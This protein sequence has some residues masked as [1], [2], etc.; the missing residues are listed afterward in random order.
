M[1]SFGRLESRPNE[2]KSM[3]SI[4]PNS[5]DVITICATWAAKSLIR[6]RS[7]AVSSARPSGRLRLSPQIGK[8]GL[9]LVALC[10]CRLKLG[11][12]QRSVRA[13]LLFGV[14]RFRLECRELREE[15]LDLGIALAQRS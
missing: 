2:C 7:C 10:F 11:L 4:G 6:L 9:S 13:Q 1:P 8:F 12:R 3:R 5:S 14:G 15:I